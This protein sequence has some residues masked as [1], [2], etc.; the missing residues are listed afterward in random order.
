[1]PELE[2][3]FVTARLETMM[4]RYGFV[5]DPVLWQIAIFVGAVLDGDGVAVGDGQAAVPMTIASPVCRMCARRVFPDCDF[6]LLMARLETVI[7]CHP[8]EPVLWQM[9]ILASDA[10]V[11]VA[12]SEPPDAAATIAASGTETA[13]KSAINR[14]FMSY[15]LVP[16]S[17]RS[18]PILSPLA[19]VFALSLQGTNRI[20]SE[21]RETIV[22]T[23]V[24]D[25]MTPGVRSVSPTDSLTDAAVAMR[26]E[27]V[28]SLPV[29]DGD[30]VVGI[31]TDRDI[32][33][34]GV[35]ERADPQTLKVGD[36][37][38]GDLVTVQPDED[39]DEA[40]ELMARHRVRRLP[41][42]EDG[43]LVGV[44]AQA[45]VALEAK[46]K[47]AGGM[48]EDISQPASTPRE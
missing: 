3:G 44:V 48:L 41:V 26:D 27:D 36:V 11:R 28:G 20:A 30:R 35:A 1:L 17:S 23:K 15:L 22:S 5:A 7:R 19:G 16:R 21:R 45:D 2:F 38:S 10:S 42:V 37:S 32:V 29:V 33:V 43:R 8:A 40:L 39:L 18:R 46:E 34:R 9:V 31:V 13:A 4:R 14:R 25:A 12:T 6:G 47:D 24:R